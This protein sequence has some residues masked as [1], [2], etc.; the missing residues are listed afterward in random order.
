MTAARQAGTE[1][2]SHQGV[3]APR[4]EKAAVVEEVKQG[5]AGAQAAVLTE[6]RGLG[7]SEMAEL[8][9][10]L[11]EAGGKYKVFKNTL[12]RR[13]LRDMDLDG[14]DSLLAGPTAI[15][16]ASD[17]VTAVVRVLRDFSRQNHA[18]V[19]KGGVLGDSVLAG[20]E[21]LKLADLPSRDVVLSQLAGVFTAPIQQVAG[22]FAALP[23][24]IAYGV[25]A[26]VSSLEQD[27]SN[28]T[29][30]SEQSGEGEG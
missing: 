27:A 4:P 5:F 3:K 21:T 8:R 12:V 9:R 19:I 1:Q 10:S 6:Y 24:S 22:L 16:F 17:D 14:I 13:A 25:T 28:P 23:R 26:L 15:A 20:P 11:G 30:G 2:P 7:V 29:A 18:L